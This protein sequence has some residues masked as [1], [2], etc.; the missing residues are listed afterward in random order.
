M[1]EGMTFLFY[2]KRNQKFYEFFKI[3]YVVEKILFFLTETEI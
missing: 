2:E 3:L 1:L